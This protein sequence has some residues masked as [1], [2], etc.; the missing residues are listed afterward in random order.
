MEEIIYEVV[1]GAIILGVILVVITLFRSSVGTIKESVNEQSRIEDTADYDMIGIENGIYSGSKIQEA[2]AYSE[3][4]SM[5]I[6]VVV[7]KGSD[8]NRVSSNIDANSY[9]SNER[10]KLHI[11]YLAQSYKRK[12]VQ[13]PFA[14]KDVLQRGDQGIV[15]MRFTFTKQ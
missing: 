13:E 2:F 6:D 3:V 4:A 5:G 10:Y 14:E 1:V 8:R 11:D 15:E 9:P 7:V 12:G